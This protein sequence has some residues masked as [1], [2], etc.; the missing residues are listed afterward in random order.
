[1]LVVP[2]VTETQMYRHSPSIHPK[3][4]YTVLGRCD[5]SIG[6]HI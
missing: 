4:I 2:E 1:M 3:A 5:F 6:K